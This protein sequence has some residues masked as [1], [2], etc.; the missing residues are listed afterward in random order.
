MNGKAE[1]LEFLID[2]ISQGAP[3][4]T[5]CRAVGVSRSTLYRWRH[6]HDIERRILKARLEGKLFHI[7]NIN[8]HAENDWRASAWLLERMYPKEFSRRT[9]IESPKRDSDDDVFVRVPTPGEARQLA[10]ARACASAGT[11]PPPITQE[12]DTDG[13]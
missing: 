10:I 9:V 4:R 8:R 11:K 1:K 5:A 3:I 6:D 13:R 12:G 7:R 2:A